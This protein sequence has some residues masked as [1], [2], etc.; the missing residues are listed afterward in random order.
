MVTTSEIAPSPA[1]APFINSYTYREF[2][3][4][5]I[6]FIKPWHASHQ[7]CIIFFFKDVPTKLVD[8]LTGEVLKT[9]TSCDVVGMSTQYNGAM[10]FNGSYSFFQ[11]IFNPHGFRTLFNAS[12][13]EITDRIVWSGDIF[14]SEI[15]L[16]HE[17]L[18]E[19]QSVAIMAELTNIWLLHYLNKKRR[20]DYKDRITATANHIIKTAGLVNMNTLA[21]YACMSVRNFERIFIN[22]TGMSAKQLCCIS[23]FN[24][25]LEL[26]LNYPHMKWTRIAHQSGYFDQMHLI[27]DFKRFCGDLPSSLLKNVP[28]LEEKYISRISN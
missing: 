6:D 18:Y 9:G 3:T 25:A 27:K 4:N 13:F 26:K 21:N 23:R 14:N 24:N 17:Q 20:I 11:I 15:K 28:L 22:E 12:P 16:F 5:G 1:L 8:T 19:S 2:D 7:S 10:T